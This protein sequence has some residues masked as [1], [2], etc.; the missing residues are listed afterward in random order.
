MV[1]K[2]TLQGERKKRK[3]SQIRWFQCPLI[4]TSHSTAMYLKTQSA[5]R[6]GQWLAETYFTERAVQCMPFDSNGKEIEAIINKRYTRDEVNLHH[7]DTMLR[8]SYH[9]HI[10][11]VLQRSCLHLQCSF[12]HTPERC[13]F[14]RAL[15]LNSQLPP[16]KHSFLSQM[17]S[18]TVFSFIL[19]CFRSAQPSGNVS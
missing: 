11:Q 16:V 10:T 13:I 19:L 3:S 1:M 15:N 12:I 18:S 6:S 7:H 17:E 9:T 4:H 2:T 8:L 14:C 5:A